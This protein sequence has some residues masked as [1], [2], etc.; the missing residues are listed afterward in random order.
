MLPFPKI[1]SRTIYF[2]PVLLVLYFILHENNAWFGLIPFPV[3]VKFTVYYFLF[4]AMASLGVWYIFKDQAKV[5][6][7]TTFLVVILLFFGSVQDMTKELLPGSFFNRYRFFLIF[8]PVLIAGVLLLLKKSNKQFYRLCQYVQ[9]TIG[10]LVMWELVALTVNVI[11]AKTNQNILFEKSQTD[12]LNIT[13]RAINGPNIYF[14]V[15][16]GFT[17]SKCLNEEFGYN[18]AEL[19]SFL[20]EKGFYPVTRSNSN[21]PVTPFSIASTLNFSYLTGE[22]NNKVLTAQDL[23]KGDKTVSQSRLIPYLHTRGYQIFNY[24]IFDLKNHPALSRTFYDMNA[25]ILYR[26]TL[27]G[28]INNDVAWNVT[29][30]TF[31]NRLLG[32]SSPFKQQRAVYLNDYVYGNM[33]GLQSVLS[34][35]QSA[36]RFVYCHIM[37][38]HD[39]YYFNKDGTLKDEN[40]TGSTQSVKKDYLNQLI[41]SRQLVKQ[42]ITS[43]LKKDT[44]NK[45]IVLEGDH[46]FS[47]YAEPNKTG[48]LFDNLNA[49]YFYDKNYAALNDSMT[50]VNTFRVVLNQYFQERLK[51]L[52]DT[53]FYVHDPFFDMGR[54][55]KNQ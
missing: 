9:I 17:S 14:I 10:I 30:N 1:I 44:L 48:R 54:H 5:V 37:L 18:N 43:I 21:Y 4:I 28:R 39:P 3:S 47:E 53:S 29:G 40:N 2:Y 42:A 25:Q 34:A 36:P 22:L 23:L 24:S 50:P 31:I 45:I 12:P 16:D 20:H 8:I 55:K 51:Y 7:F 27:A 46:G 33:N 38:P 11:S 26:Q 19:D 6:L 35:K 13:T 15:F 41:Y 52:P 32:F 49:I